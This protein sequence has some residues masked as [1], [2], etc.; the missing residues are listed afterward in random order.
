MIGGWI[1][2]GLWLAAALVEIAVL[3]RA[4]ARPVE[5]SDGA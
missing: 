5:G 1:V 3:N 4:A 2:A